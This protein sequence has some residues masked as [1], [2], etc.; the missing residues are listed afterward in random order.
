MG[1]DDPFRRA[2]ER[3]VA[4]QLSRRNITDP[5]VLKA[6]R[7]I[8][9]HRFVPPDLDRLAYSDAPLPIGHRQTISQPYIVAFMTQLLGLRGDET[10]LEIGTGSGYQAAVL[11]AVAGR[12]I[13]LERIAELAEGARRVLADL[14]LDNV[15]VHVADGSAGWPEAA[16]FQG[17]LVAAAAPKV[18]PPLLDQLAEGGRLVVPVGGSEGQVLERWTRREG[19]LECVRESAVSFVPLV[20]AHGWRSD[21]RPIED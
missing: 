13:S 12:V 3:M 6:M 5:G 16:P 17:I 20:G 10:V 9:R 1:E 7:T 2:R 11:S 8:P 19:A 21:P 18:P 4:E 14:G 15:E